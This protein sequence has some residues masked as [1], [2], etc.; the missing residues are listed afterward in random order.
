MADRLLESRSMDVDWQAD[1]DRRLAPF[2]AALRHKTRAQMCP[3]SADVAAV[4]A[5]IDALRPV[6]AGLPSVRACRRSTDGHDRRPSTRHAGDACGAIGG[7]INALLLRDAQPGGTLWLN[8]LT[9]AISNAGGVDGFCRRRTWCRRPI[10]C[11]SLR[12]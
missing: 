12:R 8:G 7:A 6:T 9:A 10:K 3:V 4:Q 2:V 11:P 1:L 5:A